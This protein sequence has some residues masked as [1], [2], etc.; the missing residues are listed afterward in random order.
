MS[1][2]TGSSRTPWQRTS[3]CARSASSSPSQTQMPY[4]SV[5]GGVAQRHE[6]SEAVWL[7]ACSRA[8]GGSESMRRR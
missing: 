7:A 4:A 5:G 2:T 6:R 3:A 8:G 1:S